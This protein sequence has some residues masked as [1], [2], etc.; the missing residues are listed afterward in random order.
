[1]ILQLLKN[2]TEATVNTHG[3]KEATQRPITVTVVHGSR[4]LLVRIS[5][6][7]EKCSFR[8]QRIRAVLTGIYFCCP[9]GGLAPYGGLPP[10]IAPVHD[11]GLFLPPHAPAPQPTAALVPKNVTLTCERLDVFSFS[12]MRRAHLALQ[13]HQQS[14]S[15]AAP[16][17]DSDALKGIMA[18]RKVAGQD[19][20]AEVVVRTKGDGKLGEEG[21]DVLDAQMNSGIGLPLAK[22]F[23]E[24]FSGPAEA[25]GTGS[26]AIWTVQ[27]FGSSATVSIPKF[28]HA[29]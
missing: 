9:G 26:L 11:T 21:E 28:G 14:T 13:A 16:D 29:S 25:P 24:Y 3:P 20:D 17:Q 10:I 8:L 4:D 6:Q 19:A 22:M 23:A 27:G 5:D 1:M 15:A 2:A 18:L 7:G 12:H